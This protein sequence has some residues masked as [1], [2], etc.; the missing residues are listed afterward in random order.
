M[1]TKIRKTNKLQLVPNKIYKS[2]VKVDNGN[3]TIE[4]PFDITEYL[5]TTNGIVF[6]YYVHGM[7]Q[8]SG[9][10]PQAVLPPL[11]LNK[12]NFRPQS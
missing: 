5:K 12:N 9:Q 10:E 7:I 8:I 1:K 2:K 3:T 4:L 6:W 11:V